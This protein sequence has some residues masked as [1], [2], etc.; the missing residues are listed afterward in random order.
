MPVKESRRYKFACGIGRVILPS[1]ANKLNIKSRFFF[2]LT[3]R[4]FVGIFVELDMSAW[5]KPYAQFLVPVQKNL[6][7][8][9]DES[10][11]SEINF[12][13]NVRHTNY[14]NQ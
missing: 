10:A 5:R 3:Y 8:K 13:V 14:K 2:C 12:V 7:L 1:F 11:R 6:I 9:Y 4:C